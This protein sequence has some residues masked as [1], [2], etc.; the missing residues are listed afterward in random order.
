[1][2]TTEPS[3]KKIIP[4]ID[5]IDNLN[6]MKAENPEATKELYK[7]IAGAEERMK[8]TATNAMLQEIPNH[9]ASKLT[10]AD[11]FIIEPYH[12]MAY[13]I[14]VALRWIINALIVLILASGVTLLY[15]SYL[16]YNGKPTPF[17]NI[18]MI[19]LEN[20]MQELAGTLSGVQDVL[21][22]IKMRFEK[23]EKKIMK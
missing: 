3:D 5:R 19:G 13:K 8:Q 23:V 16:A 21:S 7:K 17:T 9:L 18:E 20:N 15:F 1:M 4:L 14:K 11:R 22:N 6:R 10:W 2:K 12:A